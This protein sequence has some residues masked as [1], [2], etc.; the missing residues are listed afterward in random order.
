MWQQ[1][2]KANLQLLLLEAGVEGRGG[3]LL[4]GM[5]ENLLAAWKRGQPPL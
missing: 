2:E 4:R 1:L 5:E 3:G